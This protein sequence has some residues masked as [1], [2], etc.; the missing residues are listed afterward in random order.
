MCFQQRSAVGRESWS[1]SAASHLWLLY[2]FRFETLLDLLSLSCS[3]G[4][5]SSH[6]V[7]DSLRALCLLNG[8]VSPPRPIFLVVSIYTLTINIQRS[9]SSSQVDE[10]YHTLHPTFL[11]NCGRTPSLLPPPTS[12]AL[13]PHFCESSVDKVGSALYVVGPEM[14]SSLYP[15]SPLT[16]AFF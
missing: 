10:P 16:P 3:N 4:V 12:P 5:F 8:F 11:K 1:A 7:W 15:V 2:Y 9:S 6:Q 14:L 13:L